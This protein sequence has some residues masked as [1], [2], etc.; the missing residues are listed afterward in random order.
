M[1]QLGPVPVI[2]LK[3]VLIDFQAYVGILDTACNC[4][5]DP[6]LSPMICSPTAPIAAPFHTP[7]LHSTPSLPFPC[8]CAGLTLQ[9]SAAH[10]GMLC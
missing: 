5:A 9:Q 10:T 7:L 3:Q 8:P 4:T 6:A 2:L 1:G